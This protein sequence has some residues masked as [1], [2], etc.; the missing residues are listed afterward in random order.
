MTRIALLRHFPTRWNAERR[1]QGRTDVPLADD[2]RAMLGRL[3]LPSAWAE[4]LLM[5]SPLAR[6]AETASILAEGRPVRLDDRL[7][8]LSWG[9]WEG[10]CVD[11]LEAD[12]ASGF[13]PTGDLGPD[14]RPPGGESAADAWERV[15]PALARIAAEGPAVVVTHKALMRVILRR[16]RGGKGEVEIRRGRLYG[17]T[18][19]PDG[20]PVATEPPTRLVPR[21]EAA[22]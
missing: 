22:A 2:A 10:R 19:D 15:R 9:A 13:R 6:A 4:V 20:E 14:E 7:V 21:A 1:L 12:P 5:A 18:L 16:A 8:E 3:Q 11:E 17:L